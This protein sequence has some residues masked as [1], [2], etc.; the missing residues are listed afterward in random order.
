MILIVIGSF[1]IWV[2]YYDF[3]SS[4]IWIWELDYK[5]SWHPKDW[6]FWTVLLEE[7]LESPLDF[8]EIQPVHPNGD[9]SWI[10]IGSIDAEAEAPIPD[11]KN[12]FIGKN[13]GAGKD[14]RQEERGTTEDEMVEWHHQLDGHEFEQTSGV[15][16]RQGRL[17][18]W[19]PWGHE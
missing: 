15:G 19:N 7:T 14:W 13:P 8:K 6:C 5:E 2:Y 1:L 9:Q 18:C 11:V 17:R 3:S 4:H 16:D 10:F 12:W